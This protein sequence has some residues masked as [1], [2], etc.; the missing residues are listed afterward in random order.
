MNPS[1]IRCGLYATFR[2]AGG[3]PR[4]F[5]SVVKGA[6][7]SVPLVLSRKVRQPIPYYLIKA[8]NGRK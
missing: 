5:L 2:K 8:T 1:S 6:Y 3:S 7:A 4:S